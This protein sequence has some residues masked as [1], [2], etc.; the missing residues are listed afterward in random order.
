MNKVVRFRS[1]D[2]LRHEAAAEAAP[3]RAIR[4]LEL[5]VTDP[6]LAQTDDPLRRRIAEELDFAW[7]QLNSLGN[8]IA[9]DGLMAARHGSAVP[10]LDGVGKVLGQLA[11]VLRSSSPDLAIERMLGAEL[12]DR[13]QRNGSVR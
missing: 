13:L 6:A 8:A 3:R 4:R 1:L 7:R 11:A 10:T 12:R 2:Q 9:R 5:P